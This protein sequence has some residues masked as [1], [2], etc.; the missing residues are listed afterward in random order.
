MS[1]FGGPEP[2]VLED[3]PSPWTRERTRDGRSPLWSS[4][5]AA[6]EVVRRFGGGLCRFGPQKKR[7]PRRLLCFPWAGGLP[8]RGHL[9]VEVVE[10]G[11]A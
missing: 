4:H 2:T 7:R 10:V 6:S 8:Q 1:C 9:D 3:R 5:G 11:P